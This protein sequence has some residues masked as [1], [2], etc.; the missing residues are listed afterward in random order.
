MQ[1]KKK[2]NFY[3]I[4]IGKVSLLHFFLTTFDRKLD[5]DLQDLVKHRS[6]GRNRWKSTSDFDFGNFPRTSKDWKCLLILTLPG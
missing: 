3:E 4:R 5:W 6:P 2:I 1:V